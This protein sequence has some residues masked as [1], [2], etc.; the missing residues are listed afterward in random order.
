MSW[1]H[2]VS[3]DLLHWKELPVAIPEERDFMIFTGSTVVDRNNS[4]GFCQ[5]GKPCLVAAYTAHRPGSLPEDRKKPQHEAQ[6]LAW[7]T[8]RARTF[9]QYSGN[10]VLDDKSLADFRDPKVLWHEASRRW[11]MVVAIP[12]ERKVRFFTSTDL[13]EWSRTGE[14]GPAGAVGGDWECPELFELPVDARSSDTRW[15][16]KV[17][18]NPGHITGGS[19]EQYFIG[20][21]D[22]REFR[23]ENPASTTLWTDYGRDC[24]CALT[25]NGL[26]R[27]NTAT[28]IGW[29]NNWQYADKVPTSPWRGQMTLPLGTLAAAHSGG[30]PA[31]A[32]CRESDAQAARPATGDTRGR[33]PGVD[34]NGPSRRS[35]RGWVEGTGSGRPRR[36]YRLRLSGAAKCLSIEPAPARS[37]S[38]RSSRVAR[39]LRLRSRMA[40]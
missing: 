7:S 17:G 2:A 10:P 36:G 8:D 39:R 28:L 11:V 20:T 3:P 40:N 6:H 21:F 1:G 16:L 4:S 23:N 9:T 34:R 29:M 5:G 38:A 35:D 12:K 18:I 14:F 13:K 33:Q 37:D 25:F 30:N 32:G 15:V 26:P 24:Y 31:A 22:G 27:G 19:G